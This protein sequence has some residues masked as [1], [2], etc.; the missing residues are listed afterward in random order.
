MARERD[1]A[2]QLDDVRT[3]RNSGK[4]LG[5]GNTGQWPATRN[6]FAHW[7]IF[8]KHA[9]I[10]STS[11]GDLQLWALFFCEIFTIQIGPMLTVL[12]SLRTS[13]SDGGGEV[14][15]GV[16]GVVCGGGVCGGSV[17]GGMMV[18]FRL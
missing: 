18:L 11:A 15:G 10:W 4:N 3:G 8:T 12:S 13:S 17:R 6:K 5:I 14:G 16:C 9:A 2:L 1:F 7:N